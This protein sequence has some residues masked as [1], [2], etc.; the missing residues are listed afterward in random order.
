MTTH[1]RDRRREDTVTWLTA[2]TPAGLAKSTHANRSRAYEHPYGFTVV[3]LYDSTP[4]GWQLRIHAWPPLAIQLERLRDN[5]TLTQQ[6][7]CHGW[8][9]YSRVLLGTLEERL[10]SVEEERSSSSG[11]YTVTSDYQAGHSRLVLA[12]PGVAARQTEHF[13]R[14]ATDEPYLIPT[15][16]YHS[17]INIR[18]D[19]TL[20]LVATEIARNPSSLLVAPLSKKSEFLND[21]KRSLDVPTL[22]D[23]LEKVL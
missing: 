21:R 22:M 16:Q 18:Q 2:Q 19:W 9:I 4:P 7:H 12:S 20:S 1:D 14:T 13:L 17:S 6:V 10:F 5:E 11:L 8:D 23:L 3:R 15:G